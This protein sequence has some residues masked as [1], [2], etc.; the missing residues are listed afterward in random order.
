M[1]SPK[2]QKEFLRISMRILNDS[3][4]RVLFKVLSAGV[5]FWILSDK[6]F[7]RVLRDSVLFRGLSDRVLLRVLSGRVIFNIS[8]ISFV[9]LYITFS[10][11]R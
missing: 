4:D 8:L 2:S 5:L 3:N 10:K 11:R 6:V 1:P 9:L 7:F